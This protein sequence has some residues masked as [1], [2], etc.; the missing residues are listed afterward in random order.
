[1]VF[2]ILSKT[3][4]WVWPLLTGTIR[5]FGGAFLGRGYHLLG[6]AKPV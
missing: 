4:S 6:L 2:Q 3:P 1:M 5:A